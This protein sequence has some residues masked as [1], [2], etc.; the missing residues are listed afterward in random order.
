VEAEEKQEKISENGIGVTEKY[1]RVSDQVCA[2][3][4]I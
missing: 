4:G 3:F 1:Q 2:S